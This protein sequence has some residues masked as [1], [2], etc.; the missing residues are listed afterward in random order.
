M[1]IKRPYNS[2]IMR[3]SGLYNGRDGTV[4]IANLSN[5]YF[6][7]LA[8]I[9]SAFVRFFHWVEASVTKSVS[10]VKSPLVLLSV[11]LSESLYR[12]SPARE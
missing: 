3:E 7:D 8:P 10:A 9:P 11:Q 4:A 12:L 6:L 1:A 2:R 5:C